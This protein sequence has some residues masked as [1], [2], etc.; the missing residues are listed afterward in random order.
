MSLEPILQTHVATP[1][2]MAPWRTGT[3]RSAE[4]TLYTE[5]WARPTQRTA[6]VSDCGQ[7]VS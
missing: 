5:L 6:E 7:L 2:M 3:V 4:Q 1:S